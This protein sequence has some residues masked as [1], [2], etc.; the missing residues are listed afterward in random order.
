MAQANP[1]LDQELEV[2]AGVGVGGKEDP[3][4]TGLRPCP[5]D[6]LILD[7]EEETGP[8]PGSFLF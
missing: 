6:L 7:Q 2:G 5:W 8:W 4:D 3:S 1:P